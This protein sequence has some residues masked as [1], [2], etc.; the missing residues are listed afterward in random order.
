[1]PS[2]GSDDAATALGRFGAARPPLIGRGPQFTRPYG[3]AERSGA[4]ASRGED[5]LISL[6]PATW[7]TRAEDRLLGNDAV[8][9]RFQSTSLR[10]CGL[11]D[12]A[13]VAC[14]SRKVERG[15]MS[16]IPARRS[17]P[18]RRLKS[19]PD[20]VWPKTHPAFGSALDRLLT[21]ASVSS[22]ILRTLP[23]PVVALRK[24]G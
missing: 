19:R 17:A 13:G 6:R 9:D 2:C 16:I 18:P 15:G 12:D 23:G 21:R 10:G 7:L 22:Q 20:F 24:I 5:G 11:C 14:A 8:F 3:G 4:S 1:M